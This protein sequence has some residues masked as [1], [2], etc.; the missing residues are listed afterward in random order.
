MLLLLKE[1][2]HSEDVEEVSQ[3]S[4]CILKTENM[5]NFSSLILINNIYCKEDTKKIRQ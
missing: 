3:H 2:L 5:T 4:E 1:Y